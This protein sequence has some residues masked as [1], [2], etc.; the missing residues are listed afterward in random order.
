MQD[1]WITYETG[2]THETLGEEHSAR[3]LFEEVA[4]SEGELGAVIY[5]NDRPPEEL[6]YKG[7]ALKKLDRQ[8]ESEA[9]FHAMVDYG[10]S[11]LNDTV[12]MDYFA[13]SLPD[14]LVF[15]ADLNGQNE[16]HCR[17]LMMLGFA[18]LGRTAEAREQIIALERVQADHRGVARD[19]LG[20][21]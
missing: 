11:H 9:L 8:K 19:F 21:E 6:F 10:H 5:Y 14:F 16:A 17:F 1:N 7:L 15:D 13:V 2:L 12:A 4:A 18:G 20:Y 3:A